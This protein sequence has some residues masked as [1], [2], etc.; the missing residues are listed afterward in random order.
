MVSHLSSPWNNVVPCLHCV[1]GDSEVAVSGFFWQ[2]GE[3]VFLVSN[4]HCFSGIDPDNGKALHAPPTGLHFQAYTRQSEPDAENYYR[5][6]FTRI[7]VALRSEL[8]SSPLWLEHPTLGR[9]VDVAA[10]DV[11]ENVSGGVIQ[12]TCANVLETDGYAPPAV[13][14]DIFI[15]G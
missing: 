6:G 12:A 7:D 3:R 13:S 2:L 11:T 15:L 5:I 1:A 9:K 8:T 10:I 14:E 4:W